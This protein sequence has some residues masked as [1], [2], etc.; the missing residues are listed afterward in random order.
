MEANREASEANR[1]SL[2]TRRSLKD[3]EI[4][5]GGTSSARRGIPCASRNSRRIGAVDI[6]AK[7]A[8]NGGKS[9]AVDCNPV[10]D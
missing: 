7:A 2:R 9:Y 5:P 8:P 3:A 10:A 4:A 1:V 6:K